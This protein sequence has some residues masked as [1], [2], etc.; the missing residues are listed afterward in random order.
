MVFFLAIPIKAAE[1][2]SHVAILVTAR[3]G[4]IGFMEGMWPVSSKD[5]YMG[6]IFAQ[7][8]SACLFDKDGEF[9]T[10]IQEIEETIV[11]G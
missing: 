8:F 2:S 11:L 10:T 1:K 4:H 6:R 9:T 5:Q 7:Y 3:G